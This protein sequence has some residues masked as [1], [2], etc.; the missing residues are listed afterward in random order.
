MQTE[1]TLNTVLALGGILVTLFL[2]DLGLLAVGV[3]CFVIGWIACA[4]IT[5]RS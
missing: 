3:L 5:S 4:Q 1:P 2:A